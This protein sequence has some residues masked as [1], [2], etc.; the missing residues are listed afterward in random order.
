MISDFYNALAEHYHLIFEDWDRS[1]ARQRET[2]AQLLAPLLPAGQWKVLDCACGIGTQAI[3]FAQDGHRVVA[4]DLSPAA[5][6]RARREAA[7]RLLA[8]E[9]H[10]SDMT[11]LAEIGEQDF[12]IVTA[13]DNALPHLEPTPLRQAVHAMAG[14]L[15]SGGVFLASIRDYDR[16]LVERPTI[17]PPAFHSSDRG[18]WFVH[19]VWDWHDETRY[20]LHHYITENLNGSWRS[21]HFVGE[22][23]CVTRAELTEALVEGGLEHIRW[24]TPEESGFYQPVVL[25]TRLVR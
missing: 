18:R 8:I 6:A 14:R 19:Q 10:V 23:R 3:G 13:M 4:C 7:Q 21:H 5:I 9:F 11:V 24:L 2:L 16:L 22:Y 12:D 20:T 15:R 17:Q 25:G 1:I